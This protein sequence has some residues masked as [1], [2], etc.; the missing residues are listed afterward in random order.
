MELGVWEF[1][2]GGGSLPPRGNLWKP[3]ACP[4]CQAAVAFGGGLEGFLRCILLVVGAAGD[5][6][7]VRGEAVLDAHQAEAQHRVAEAVADEGEGAADVLVWRHERRRHDDES[8]RR[9]LLH[10]DAQP[11][12]L[13]G[14]PTRGDVLLQHIEQQRALAGIRLGEVCQERRPTL[15]IPY[16]VVYRRQRPVAEHHLRQQQGTPRPD[17]PFFQIRYRR[18]HIERHET[19]IRSPPPFEK[20]VPRPFQR[21]PE[22]VVVALPFAYKELAARQTPRL[23]DMPRAHKCRP[24]TP[25]ESEHIQ[26][27]FNIFQN[28]FY[29]C[30]DFDF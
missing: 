25:I 8:V 1:F 15:H 11:E 19:V 28:A 5:D 26:M 17:V 24:V 16:L 30:H 20:Q 27:P 6:T 22:G 10:R 3:P 13:I 14:S 4:S 2:L 23:I 12:M 7:L 21:T 29:T 18:E 9:H